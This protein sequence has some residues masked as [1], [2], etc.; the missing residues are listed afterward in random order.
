MI[1]SNHPDRFGEAIPVRPVNNKSARTRI[2]MK[3]RWQETLDTQSQLFGGASIVYL[4]ISKGDYETVVA[5]NSAMDYMTSRTRPLGSK[6]FADLVRHY[7]R[8]MLVEDGSKDVR[9]TESMEVALG[10]RTLM[11]VP[12]YDHRQEM[13]GIFLFMLYE[14]RNI[15]N[16]FIKT[17]NW[18]AMSLEE[19]V[20][21]LS[22]EE[23]I[24][25]IRNIDPLTRLVSKDRMMA[26]IKVEFERSK[27]S[28]M[29]F[30]MVLLDI[31]HFHDINDTFGYMVGDSVL[32]EFSR[33]IAGRI[34]MVDTACRWDGNAFAILCPQTDLINANSLV[35]DLFDSLT[36][37]HFRDVGK[38]FFSMG[39]AD[40]SS[41]DSSVDDMLHRLDKAI[42]RVKAFGGNSHQAS[43]H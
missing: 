17:V 16:N 12:I 14:A 33:I 34:R 10:Y 20:R 29:P 13:A 1:L 35:N 36:K 28:G 27:R 25:S 30:S 39:L 22:V 40:F 41:K 26:I 6:N 42:Y 32:K 9:L 37:H 11:G 3:E 15:D 5:N 38:C 2:Y 43:Y 21:Y 19:S 23:E 7:G 24:H 8:M 4:G 31:D 18:L